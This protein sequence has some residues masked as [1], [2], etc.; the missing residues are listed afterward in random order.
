VF[1][2]G[3]STWTYNASTD[4]W[5]Q[6][7]TSVQPPGWRNHVGMAYDSRNKVHILYGGRGGADDTW[8]YDARANTWTEMKPAQHPWTGIDTMLFSYDPEHNVSVLSDYRPG[9]P[10]WVYRYSNGGTPPPQPPSVTGQPA[11]R[12]IT[13]GQTAT[14]AVTA[15]G[16]P[17]LSYQWQRNGSIL[18]GSTESSY[19]TPPTTLSESGSTFRV[20][21]S[22]SAGSVTSNAAV[23]TVNPSGAGGDSTPSS[24][25][26]ESHPW[27]CGATGLEAALI[28]IAL[29]RRRI[30]HLSDPS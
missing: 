19:T 10:L 28:L 9:S 29:R 1:F 13:E 18:A 26:T 21:V 7:F 27:G 24:G 3:G 22:N 4:V 23:I 17:P 30:P 20:L 25:K 12:T 6:K 15:T 14:F 2:T 5:T 8:A 16:T 11:D